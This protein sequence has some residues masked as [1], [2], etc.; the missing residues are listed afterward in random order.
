MSLNQICALSLNIP[1]GEAIQMIQKASGVGNWWLAASSQL[2]AGSCIMSRE[3]FLAKH[4]TAHVTKPT[5]SPDLALHDFWLFPKLKSPLKGKRFQTA[6]EIQE[7]MTGQLMVTGRPV[8]C[9]KIPTL[10]GTEVSWS[11]V[12]CFLYLVSSSVNVSVSH[13]TWLDTSWTDLVYLHILGW[14]ETVGGTSMEADYSEYTPWLHSFD[15]RIMYIFYIFKIILNSKG[16]C[17][18]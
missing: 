15:F 1:P 13:I 6:Y 3:K 18:S 10:E 4:Q 7:N 14:E 9:P 2:C 8:W 11:Y 5:C 12:Q 17:N 16:K